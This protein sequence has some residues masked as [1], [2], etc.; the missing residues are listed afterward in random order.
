MLILVFSRV[1]QVAPVV[2]NVPANAGD[3]RVWGS[4]PGMGRSLEE[5]TAAHSSV[6]G[7]RIPWT[8][9]PGGLHSM[10]LRE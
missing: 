1:S 8:E 9:D 5:E 6:L 2:K 3:A 10:G 4:I 7:R